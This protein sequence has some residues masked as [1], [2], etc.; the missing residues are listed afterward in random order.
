MIGRNPDKFYVK[1][2]GYNDARLKLGEWAEGRNF[3]VNIESLKFEYQT[4]EG[5]EI[6][7]I[8]ATE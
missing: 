6:W 1:A 3:K 5:L 7:S 2:D 4:I 8:E